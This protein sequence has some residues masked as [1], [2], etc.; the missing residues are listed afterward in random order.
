MQNRFFSLICLFLFCNYLSG[1]GKKPVDYVDP[2][3]GTAQSSTRWMMFPGATTP[4]GMV[5]LSPDNLDQDGWYKGGFNPKVNNIAGFSHIHA[6]TM[7]GL[8]T[9]ATTGDLKIK[10]GPQDMSQAGYRSKFSN[11]V[12]SPGYYAVTLDDYKIRAE[13]TATTRTGFHRYLFPKSEHAHILFDLKFP[14]EYGFDLVNAQIKKVSNSEIIGFCRQVE[15]YYSGPWQDYTLHFVIKFDKPSSSIGFWNGD[16]ILSGAEDTECIKDTDIGAFA[17][18]VTSE[19]EAVQVKIGFSL[20]SIEQARLNLESET[21]AFGWNFNA[22]KNQ[23]QDIWNKLLS[24]IVV[25]G[26]NETDKVK[27]YTCLYRSYC[28]RAILSDVNGKYKDMCEQTVQIKNPDSPMFGCDAFWNSFWNLNQIWSLMTPAI[29]NQ[30]VNSLLEMYDRGGWLPKGPAGIE[31][32]GIME[33]EHEI[34]LIVGAYQKRIRNFDAGKAYE[35]MK[36]MQMVQGQQQ[37]CGGFAGNFDLPAYMNLGYVPVEDGSASH[38]LEYA[39][40]D[41]CVAQM[42]KALGKIDDYNYFYK[43]SLNY[44]NIFD[45]S[46]RYMRPRGKDG[47]WIKEFDPY[48]A[49]K[50]R[51]NIY[52]DQTNNAYNDFVEGNSWQYTFFV[53]HDVTGLVKLIGKDEFNNR[54]IE[55]FQKSR[56]EK[57]SSSKYVNHG[58]QPNMQAAYLFNYSGMPWETQ[59]YAR[60]IMDVYYGSKP[61]DGYQG[62]E[63]EGQMSAW[64]VMSAMGLFEM[65]GG[66]SI[67]PVYE[68][69]SPL[70]DKTIIHLDKDYYSGNDFIIETINNSNQNRYIQSATLNGKPLNVPWLYHSVLVQ[71]GVLQLIMGPKPNKRWGSSENAM[72]TE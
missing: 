46:V 41:W 40:D 14:S 60:E 8:L 2:K 11:D 54:L 18:F 16:K 36:K 35:A 5:A 39:Y 3:I 69:G 53:P 70:F 13:L 65:D 64:F 7:S 12:A 68:I 66:T 38:T 29:T 72:K 67:N 59:H 55:G 37:G 20:V 15:R 62:D 57:Y 19:G 48:T 21:A 47:S 24:K 50:R 10:P 23:A 30:W 58:N 61:E 31:Y 63:D 22:A 9:M 17:D 56:D 52:D 44:K 6:W 28:A 4:F 71:G 32:S 33:G 49:G 1:Q 34:A 43:R 26:A 27:F 45:P 25:Q 51:S 42:A